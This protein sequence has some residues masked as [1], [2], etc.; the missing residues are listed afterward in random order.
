MPKTPTPQKAKDAWDRA[1]IIGKLLG[2]ILIPVTLAVVSYL[3]NM[4]LQERA[5]REKRLEIA[6]SV[7]QSKDT[8]TPALRTW[9]LSEFKKAVP[10]LPTSAQK[11]LETKPLPTGDKATAG[12]D[13]IAEL[14]GVRLTP[15]KD[16]T[17]IWTIGYG[18]VGGVNENTPPITIEEARDLLVADMHRYSQTIDEEV[19]GALTTNQRSALVSLIWNVGPGAFKNSRIPSLINTGKY[20]DVPAEI[21][22]FT[23]GIP[24]LKR[25]REREVETWN[26]KEPN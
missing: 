15:Y 25:R 7:L 14:E 21:L 11:E 2:S 6:I 12:A 17:G 23:H 10:E 22:K 26:R 13:L 4:S 18:H 24:A 1:D 8:G 5:A 20:A 9:A 19:K 16:A 3:V